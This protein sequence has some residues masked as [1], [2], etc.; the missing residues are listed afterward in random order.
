[1]AKPADIGV[2]GLGDHGGAFAL[3]LARDWTVAV[4]DDD[5]H[6]VDRLVFND[7]EKG[8][9]LI[10]CHSMDDL[11]AELPPTPLVMLCQDDDAALEEAAAGLAGRLPVGAVV[12][13]A[14][15]SHYRDTRRRCETFAGR[16]IDFCGLGSAGG[17]RHS[18]LDR[19]LMFG[20]SERA[21]ARLE[22]ILATVAAKSLGKPCLARFG[23]EGAGHFAALTLNGLLASSMQLLAEMYS[24]LRDL[25]GLDADAIADVFQRWNEGSA[26]SYLVGIAPAIMRKQDFET[27]LPL[28]DLVLDTAAG[29]EPGFW[30]AVEALRLG[31]ATPTISAAVDAGL[32]AM[33]KTERQHASTV[34]EGPKATLTGNPRGLMDEMAETLFAANLVAAAQAFDLLAAASAMFGWDTDLSAAAR[35]WHG[36]SAVRSR[37]LG[38]ARDAF[39]REPGL[40]NLLLDG[41]VARALADRHQSWRRIAAAASGAG[42]PAP[43]LF[44]ALAYYDSYRAARLPTN[45]IQAQLDYYAGHTYQRVDEEG[46]FHTFW[47]E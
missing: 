1:M 6:A 2:Y 13:D 26:E 29:D 30:A 21:Y 10:P 15:V 31:V 18:G 5:P 17:Y 16:S 42:L 27:G 36:G 22:P 45:L 14:S 39:S 37:A 24:L 47:N 40:E 4:C 23:S 41:A 44:S 32:A 35:I 12:V 46:E 38:L 3:D 8:M 19:C 34:L 28:V 33:A 9:T 43:A 25:I 7:A 20:G 11:A